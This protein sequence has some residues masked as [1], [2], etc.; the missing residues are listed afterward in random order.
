MLARG[1]LADGKTDPWNIHKGRH[2]GAL[3]VGTMG[4]NSG[5]AFG[6][7][8]P[9][10]NRITVYRRVNGLQGREGESNRLYAIY[11]RSGRLTTTITKSTHCERFR[12]GGECVQ[13]RMVFH[14]TATVLRCRMLLQRSRGHG[15]DHHREL[16]HASSIQ[17][18]HTHNSDKQ[19]E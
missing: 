4:G 9:T 15:S 16:D 1:K 14:S 6:T 18:L 7:V 11:E 12:A 10:S 5:V 2:S 17:Q 8:Q 3:S 19:E 13:T